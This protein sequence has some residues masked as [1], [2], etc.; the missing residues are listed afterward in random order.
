MRFPLTTTKPRE[1]EYQTL[2]EPGTFRLLRFD[3]HNNES[4]QSISIR[5][6]TYKI[7]EAPAYH[8]L[9]YCW[10]KK[11]AT[12]QVVSD[13]RALRVTATLF[14][15]LQHLRQCVGV[16]TGSLAAS[17]GSH[18]SDTTPED[19]S[20]LGSSSASGNS[21]TYLWVD[22][23]CIDQTST[24]ERNQQVALMGDIYRGAVRTV[25][26]LGPNQGFA[27]E[28]FSLIRQIFVVVEGEKPD[29]K[30]IANFNM[31]AYDE[32]RHIKWGLPARS[33]EG[34]L[35]LETLLSRPWFERLWVI[36][37]AVLSRRDALVVCGE[38]VCSWY[39]VSAACSWLHAKKYY[40][41]GYCPLIVYNVAIV[42]LTSGEALDLTSLLHLEAVTFE[43]TD[44]RDKV[45]GLLG[46]A[47]QDGVNYLTADYALSP[48]E[49]WR[50]FS[51][52]LVSRQGKLTLLNM[53]PC[54]NKHIN[55]PFR[56]IGRQTQ[57][58][59][60][61]SWV[62]NFDPQN[63]FYRF[64]MTAL[65]WDREGKRLDMKWL[66]PYSAS[67]DVSAV[68]YD[69]SRPAQPVDLSKISLKGLQVDK[70]CSRFEVNTFRAMRWQLQKWGQLDD[71]ENV[72]KKNYQG[73]WCLASFEMYEHFLG[74]RVP[75]ALRLWF[76]VLE[77]MPDRD[78]LS[79]ARL[80]CEAMTMNVSGL[81]QLLG[82]AD[83][84]HFCAYMVKLHDA[85]SKKFASTHTRFH[86][87]FELL[88]Q[89]AESGEVAQYQIAVETAC[90]IRRCFITMDGRV[91]IGSTSLKKGDTIVVLFG[92]G[93]PYILR[94][95]KTE[96]LFIGECYVSGLMQGE[97]IVK[98]RAGELQE[99]CFDIV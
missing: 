63:P 91:G 8:A 23:I 61:P 86:Q 33:A 26:W 78:V 55:D 11:K 95:W 15:A 42:R 25:I 36:Q 62:P 49:T 17:D 30:N 35:A 98:W 93:T 12:K 43:A 48:M 71:L 80:L 16:T 21:P 22:Q 56:C 9:S 20:T 73:T 96:W 52:D 7:A 84:C 28:A 18:T 5:L 50:N 24:Q 82:D 64:N 83:F 67:G 75:I 79:L 31:E 76:K 92:G 29:H 70:I 65:Q 13:G 94:R 44:P 34:W 38:E 88:Q 74:L 51:R 3:N 68:R 87:S 47:A 99:E 81:K 32:D 89:Y 41:A 14:E 37:E 97:A 45:F 69:V 53:P 40:T 19:T 2:T 77:Y 85:W 6:E 27:K 57:W 58:T 46:L 59:G 90:N 10:G 60:T 39:M 66:Q 1:Y 72:N 54:R 4:E